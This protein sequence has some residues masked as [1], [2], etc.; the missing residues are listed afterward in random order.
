MFKMGDLVKFE[1]LARHVSGDGWEFH[2][3]FGIILKHKSNDDSYL[4]VTKGG[5]VIESIDVHLDLIMENSEDA[6]KYEG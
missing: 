3:G 1:Y 2:R 5:K 6:E 4:I